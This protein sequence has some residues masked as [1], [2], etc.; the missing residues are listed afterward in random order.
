MRI[1]Y[2]SVRMAL[3]LGSLVIK[4]PRLRFPFHRFKEATEALLTGRWRGISPQL[5]YIG[6]H[7]R[8]VIKQNWAEFRT[9]RSLRAEF[10]APTYFSCGVLTIGRYIEGKQPDLYLDLLPLWKG[11][12][13]TA[14]QEFE[15][16]DPH[17]T[18][19]T[20]NILRTSNGYCFV[21]YGDSSGE[22]GRFLS[23]NQAEVA[24]LFRR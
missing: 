22:L 10:L 8:T 2:G 3:I 19:T 20:A 7:F 18:C 12:S 24:K 17:S 1:K 14:R 5:G 4:V 11:L 9:W 6:Y 21:D 23:R 13:P 16:V 15:E